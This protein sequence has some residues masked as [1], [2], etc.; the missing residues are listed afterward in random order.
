M[1]ARQ[2]FLFLK[3]FYYLLNVYFILKALKKEREVIFPTRDVKYLEPAFV[4]NWGFKTENVFLSKIGFSDQKCVFLFLS[5]LEEIKEN[6]TMNSN[7][8]HILSFVKGCVPSYLHCPSSLS[9]SLV[10]L[11]ISL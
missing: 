6:T 3:M 9:M 7:I 2:T 5:L 1:L 10:V 4:Q 8:S 11:C